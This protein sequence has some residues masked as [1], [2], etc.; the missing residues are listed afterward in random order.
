MKKSNI[1]NILA[2]VNNLLICGGSIEKKN[3]QRLIFTLQLLTK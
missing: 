1:L 3:S 2:G